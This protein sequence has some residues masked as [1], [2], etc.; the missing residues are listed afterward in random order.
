MRLEDLV[1][2]AEQNENFVF[3]VIEPDG[4]HRAGLMRYDGENA[5]LAAGSPAEPAGSCE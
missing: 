4:S 1:R 5:E 3:V 2:R